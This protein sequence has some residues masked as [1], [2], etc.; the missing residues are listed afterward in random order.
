MHP[1]PLF[2]KLFLRPISE[3]IS[4][5]HWHTYIPI[6]SSLNVIFKPIHASYLSISKLFIHPISKRSFI[7][8]YF[9]IYFFVLFPNKSLYR[10]SILPNL[11]LWPIP[12]FTHL[13]LRSVSLFLILFPNLF[14]ILFPNYFTPF[15]YFQTYFHDLFNYFQT[16]FLAISQFPHIFLISKPISLFP[17]ISFTLLP[18]QLLY[19]ISLLLNLFI[20]PILLFSNL[21]LPNL[22]LFS[23]LF[24]YF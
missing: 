16:N 13:F 12:L 3:P 24:P 4:L 15:P 11:F 6:F 8:P 21:F 10:I 7:F 23:N 20:W 9:Q 5:S 2:P 19:P 22:F 14:L 1:Y 17:N 18:N